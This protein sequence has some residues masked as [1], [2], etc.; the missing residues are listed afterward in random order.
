MSKIFRPGC[1]SLQC[2]DPRISLI[3]FRRWMCEPMPERQPVTFCGLLIRRHNMQGSRS[4]LFS[5]VNDGA[6]ALHPRSYLVPLADGA[7]ARHPPMFKYEDRLLPTICVS[8]GSCGRTVLCVTS[9]YV[10]GHFISFNWAS[11]PRSIPRA[12][13]LTRRAS[14][15]ALFDQ[16][17]NAKDG[18]WRSRIDI[19][20]SRL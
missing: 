7:I 18:P 11:T 3:L 12:G 2:H 6:P 14:I 9:I 4:Y 10:R 8:A 1:I 17:A 5:Q 15:S 20:D 19:I 16:F 13:N